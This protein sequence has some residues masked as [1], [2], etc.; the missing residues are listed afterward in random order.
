MTCTGIFTW[1]F[2]TQTIFAKHAMVL[3]QLYFHIHV[4]IY[5][6]I[7]DLFLSKGNGLDFRFNKDVE[8]DQNG[9][10]SAVSFLSDSL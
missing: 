8:R 3:V 6:L 9:I 10:Y 2:Q 4:M 5:D 7:T 1:G